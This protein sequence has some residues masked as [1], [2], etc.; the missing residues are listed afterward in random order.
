MCIRTYLL[1]GNAYYTVLRKVLYGI[2][3]IANQPKKGSN[4]S[5]ISSGKRRIL[6]GSSI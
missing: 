4:K 1:Y 6:T 2:A 3:L 5:C